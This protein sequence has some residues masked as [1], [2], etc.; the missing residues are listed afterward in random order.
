MTVDRDEKRLWDHVPGHVNMGCAGYHVGAGGCSVP[1]SGPRHPFSHCSQ[2]PTYCF[3]RNCPQMKEARQ[4]R[5]C[6]HPRDRR[7]SMTGQP[8]TQSHP[9]FQF[10]TILRNL[11]ELMVPK[12]A[13]MALAPL[14]S[15][16]SV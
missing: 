13:I 8:G 3:S 9:L 16:S 11:L 12:K 6:P 14:L 15:F 4:P 2:L 10:R 7:G 1:G 5:L